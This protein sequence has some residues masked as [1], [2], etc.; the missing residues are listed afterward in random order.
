MKLSELTTASEDVDLFREIAR[1]LDVGQHKVGCP[2][3]QGSR[4]KHRH[5]KP[6]SIEVKSDGASFTC[7]HCGITG[8]FDFEDKTKYRRSH[9]TV[10]PMRPKISVPE[11]IYSKEVSEFLDSRQIPKE[12][13]EKHT[14][15]GEWSFRGE[16]REAVG[17][18][19]RMAGELVAV[20]WRSAD[21]DKFFSQQGV[22]DQLWNLENVDVKKPLLICEG[23]IDALTWLSIE[24]IDVNV[25]SVPNGAP[26]KAGQND[27]KKFHYLWSARDVLSKIEQIY[28]SPDNDEPGANLVTEITTRVGKGKCWVIDLEGSKD[29]NDGLTSRGPEWWK[30]RVVTAQP[31]PLQGLYD[32]SHYLEKFHDLYDHG[33]SIGVSSGFASLDAHLRIAPGMV[34]IVTGLPGH[35]KSDWLD[36]VCIHLAKNHG[37]RTIYCSFE[38]PPELHMAQMAQKISSKPFFRGPNPRMTPEERDAAADWISEHFF[39]MDAAGAMTIDDVLDF[40]KAAV[41]R[42]SAKVLVIDPFNYLQVDSKQQLETNAIS[43]VLTKTAQFA[44]SHDVAV[45]FVSHP[46]KPGGDARSGKFVA[47]GMDVAGSMAWYAKSDMGVTIVRTDEGPECH[48]WKVRW[49]W[50]GTPGHADLSYDPVSTRWSDRELI[51]DTFDWNL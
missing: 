43:E 46:A 25:V 47:G 32:S 51:E 28:V 33:K 11:N 19:Y 41:L 39:F 29:A 23:E 7:H 22:C 21:S 49:A 6:L 16:R 36:Q 30:E 31:I 8:G 20:K 26:A 27:G 38:K 50:L 13:Y 17:F 35:G 15:T 37:Y 2:L 40:A 5:D 9:R 4:R 1:R 10:T 3:C 42:H 24:G 45:F 14:I 18:P 34:T 12:I 48:V 44:K